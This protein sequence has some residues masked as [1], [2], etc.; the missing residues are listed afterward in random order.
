MPGPAVEHR[1]HDAAAVV[2][3]RGDGVHMR[4]E[5]VADL[6]RAVLEDGAHSPRAVVED[7]RHGA[8]MGAPFRLQVRLPLL[9]RFLRGAQLWTQGFGAGQRLR[10]RLASLTAGMGKVG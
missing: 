4:V 8:G 6:A 3:Y 9:R 1:A 10:R 2:E 5:Q 7:A